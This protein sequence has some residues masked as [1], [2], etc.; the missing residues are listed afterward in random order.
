MRMEDAPEYPRPYITTYCGKSLSFNARSEADFCVLNELF[1]SN[2]YRLSGLEIGEGE[3]IIDIGAHIGAFSAACRAR[4]PLAKIISLEPNP[5]NFAALVDHNN[6]NGLELDMSRVAVWTH[7]HGVV[8]IHEGSAGQVE[9]A[10]ADSE[11]VVPSI[12]FDELLAGTERVSLLK[13]DIEGAEVPLL[14]G[15]SPDSLRKI[16]RIHGEF[17]GLVADWGEWVR[18]LGAFFE[19]TIVPHPYPL[20]IYGGMFYGT[21]R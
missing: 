19:L 4:F 13:I 21:R 6:A 12:T 16:D 8:T 3:V 1:A 20:Q 2:D 10:T 18:W 7:N 15:A 14:L 11:V 17:H 5:D 9:E